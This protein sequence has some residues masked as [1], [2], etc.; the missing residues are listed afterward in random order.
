MRKDVRLKQILDL[1]DQRG[2]I[3][4]ESLSQEFFVS[5]PTIYRDLRE[6]SR[7]NLIIH[8]HGM[9]QP[10][11]IQTVTTP[12]DFRRNLNA[13]A[14][15]AIAKAAAAL[16]RDHSTIFIDASTTASYLIGELSRFRNLQV[17]TNGLVTAVL[18]ARAGIPTCCLGG[19]PVENSLAVGGPR[20]LELLQRF[21]VDM[22]LF[23]AYGVNSRGIIVD[24]SEEEVGLRRYALQHTTSV[25]LCD[26][27]KFGRNSIFQ[28]APLSEVDYLVTDA[29]LTAEQAPV[30]K[31]V[32][33][34]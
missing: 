12:F 6:L 19:T 3:T 11:R 2:A 31:Q 9:V 17:V 8:N 4:A 15:A 13:P 18:L 14:K 10:A 23:S 33:T 22:M 30:R 1:L 16:I 20:T 27:S 21:D 26:E 7:Q 29:R 5:L 28:V 24:P 34:V 25:L 32:L